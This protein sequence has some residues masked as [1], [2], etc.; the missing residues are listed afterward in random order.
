MSCGFE[1][2]SYFSQDSCLQFA[3]VL[4]ALCIYEIKVGKR[5]LSFRSTS[6]FWCFLS[7]HH[8]DGKALQQASGPLAD[9]GFLHLSAFCPKSHHWD[10]EE[11]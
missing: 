3:Q 9:P 8:F 5:G 11:K 2:F 10:H 4:S 6:P 7:R 1:V